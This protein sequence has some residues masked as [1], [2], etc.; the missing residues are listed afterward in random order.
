MRRDQRRDHP[1]A[2][3][4]AGRRVRGMTLIELMISAGLGVVVLVAGIAMLLAA[5]RMRR[6]QE[7]LSDANEE[8]RTALRHVARSLSS[9]GAGGSLFAFRD[10][11][12]VSQMGS[13]ISFKNGTT[14]LHATLPQMPDEL[15]LLRYATDRRSSLLRPL[16]GNKVS[17]SPDPRPATTP[18]VVTN[19]I[20]TGEA[21]L[22][23]NFQRAMLLPVQGTQLMAGDKCVDLDV[24]P[25]DP[26]VLQDKLMPIEPGAAVLPVQVVRY[27]LI[28]RPAK[29]SAKAR[30]DFLMETLEPRTLLKA[31]PTVMTQTVLARDVEDFQVQWAYDRNDDGVPDGGYTDIGPSTTF[32]DPSLSFAR[33]SLSARTTTHLVTEQGEFK[34]KGP[35]TP[36]EVGLDT[37][38][39]GKAPASSTQGHRRRVVSTVVVLKNLAASRM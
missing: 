18:G 1:L 23:T 10:V 17:V 13:A 35:K 5:G 39:G 11:D 15:V 4:R 8:A 3:P 16:G 26:L 25:L 28:Y 30:A 7:L 37:S 14:V 24:S 32:V 34:P 38:L 27:R 19:I 33:I 2:P 21:A 6:N 31:A 12:N 9:A 22:V 29:G 20:S 36:F